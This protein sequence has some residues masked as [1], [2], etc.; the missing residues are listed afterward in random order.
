VEVHWSDAAEAYVTP[1][2]A[3]LIGIAILSSHRE[4]YGQLLASFPAL[5]ARLADA[6]TGPVSGAG[7]LRQEV[8]R[9][10]AGRVLLVGDAAGYV[11]ALTGEG[12]CLGLRCAQALVDNLL[13]NTPQHYERDYRRITRSHRLITGGLVAA[14][15]RRPIRRAIVPVAAAAPPVF[16]TVVAALA[17]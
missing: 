5:Q 12:L 16:R 3:D 8:G 2:A 9:R 6:A 15:R 11:D 7:P 14:A 10:V 13:R 1:V 4:H 17:R